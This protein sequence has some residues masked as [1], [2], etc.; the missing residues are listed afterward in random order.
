M[1]TRIMKQT[2]MEQNDSQGFRIAARSEVFPNLAQ[3]PEH[4][5]RVCLFILMRLCQEPVVD[6]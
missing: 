5:E 2:R 1:H 4:Y 6:T 3:Q